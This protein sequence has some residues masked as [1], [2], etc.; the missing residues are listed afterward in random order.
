MSHLK[1]FVF[2]VLAACGTFVGLA[3]DCTHEFGAITRV[4]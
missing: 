1:C 2:A 4:R 3:E